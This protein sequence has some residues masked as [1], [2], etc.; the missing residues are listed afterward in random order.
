M[1]RLMHPG[2]ADGIALAWV[3]A[4]NGR[5]ERA[6]NM[7]ANGFLFIVFLSITSIFNF[8]QYSGEIAFALIIT[9]TIFI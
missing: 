9:R 1:M 8:C 6:I 3:R 4:D 5:T 2:G 7:L